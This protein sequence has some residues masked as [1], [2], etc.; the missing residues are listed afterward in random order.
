MS[1]TKGQQQLSSQAEKEGPTFHEILV[2][3]WKERKRILTISFVVALLTLGVNFIL[4]V[5]YKSTATL[6]PETQKDKLSSLGQFADIASLAGVSVPGSEIARLYPTII[7]SETVLKAVVEKK[8]PSERHPEPVTLIQYFEFD[9]PTYYLNLVNAITRLRGLI[10]ASHDAKTSVVSLAIE[11]PEPGLAAMVLNSL[12]DELDRFMRYKRVN[13]ASEQVKW[14]DVRIKE[15]ESELRVAEETLK[16]FRERNRRVGDSPQLLLEQ[17]RFTRDVQVKSTVYIELKKQYELAR[18][19]EIKNLTIVNVLDSAVVPTK[20]E[21]PKRATNAA[22][23]FLLTF[24]GTSTYYA[25]RSLYGGKFS[26]FFGSI[27][28]GKSNNE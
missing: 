20:K 14:I 25:S 19:D 26:E 11:M 15:V 22:I 8:Y 23:M 10:S 6:L 13:N 4:P 12:I 2:P 27:K 5:Y 18:L 16:N 21:R 3:V 1:E 7:L 17:E 9:N 28:R 24:L